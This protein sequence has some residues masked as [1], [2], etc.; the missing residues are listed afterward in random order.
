MKLSHLYK[1]IWQFLQ[2][3]LE[4]QERLIAFHFMNFF[5]K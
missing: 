5:K 1:I 2:G 3:I 4:T